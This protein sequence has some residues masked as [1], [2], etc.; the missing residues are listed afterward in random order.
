MSGLQVQ[1]AIQAGNAALS[2]QLC[3]CCCENRLAIA[4]QTNAIQNNLAAN[5]AAATLQAAQNQ[6][7]LQL[8]NAEKAAAD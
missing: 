4:N 7:A 6:A 3:Q 5:H 8:Q 2:Q 1:N